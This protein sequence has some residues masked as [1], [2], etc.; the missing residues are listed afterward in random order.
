MFVNI[1][2]DIYEYD[3]YWIKMIILMIINIYRN[4]LPKES[5]YS[6]TWY[7]F[8]SLFQHQSFSDSIPTGYLLWTWSAIFDIPRDYSAP[9]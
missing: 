2:V 1:V 5:H 4:G 8:C 3:E 6:P 9:S 7:K